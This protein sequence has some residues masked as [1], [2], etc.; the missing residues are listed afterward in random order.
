MSEAQAPDDS[1]LATRRDFAQA[2]ALLIGAGV[3][4][5]SAA[6]DPKPEP[7]KPVQPAEAYAAL[8][9]SRFGKHLTDEQLQK[10]VA[11]VL[12]GRDR[13]TL[14]KRFPL[15]DGDEPAFVFSAD[16]M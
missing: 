1:P 7:P 8:V 13:G 16:P 5:P 10:V 6:Q 11:S 2:L 4:A 9:R 3:A 15:A 12:R 14:L